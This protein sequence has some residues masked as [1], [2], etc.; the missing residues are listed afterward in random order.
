MSELPIEPVAEQIW[1]VPAGAR[2][3]MR[4]PA[5]VFADDELLSAICA[6]HSLEQLANVATLP[7]IVEAALAMPDIHQGYGFPVGGV[8][9]TEP[10]GGVVS[11]G[12]VGYDIN[13]G[14]RLL[15]LPL[16]VGELG[17][18]RASLV[19][20]IAR[21]VP[22]G[23]GGK[24]SRDG[25]RGVR[26]E[27]VLALGPRALLEDL[28]IGS[29]EELTVTESAGCLAGADPGQLSPRALER[30]AGQIG[31]LGSGN[32][33]LELQR[34]DRLYDAPSAR[35][36][37][38]REGQVTILI[39][40]GSRGLGHQVCTDF[41]KRMDA[42]LRHYGIELPDRQLSCAPL[43][44]PEAQAYLGAMAAAANFAWANRAALAH[45]ARSAVGAVLGPAAARGLRQVYD[46]AHNVAKLE[47]HD[48][49]TLC[50]HRKGA[51][52]AF[53]PGHPELP[54]AYRDAGQPVFIPGS[55]G[56]SSFVLAGRPRALELSFGT[57][58]HGAGRRLSRTAVRKQVRGEALRDRLERQGIAVQAGSARGLAEEAPEAYKDV[59]R[60]V[61][62]VQAVG[63]AAKVAQ[64]RPIGVIKG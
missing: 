59:E 43:D 33:F 55:M 26:L 53:P 30:G 31:T 48:G 23:A 34:V 46:V 40:S 52:R 38:L 16:D 25:L 60:V 44:S 18:R 35:A 49:R 1:E 47:Q 64:L 17:G 29:E 15:A 42:R 54:A 28:G 50:V 12:G 2:A 3:G 11:P 13:C 36:F 57:T 5:R 32:H 4:V 8:A 22:V 20:E 51:T 10:P 27:R 19:R 45:R 21:R 39:H 41:V 62:V 14:V 58:C 61:D 24:G 63:L 6:D 7:G 56:T 9:A 37:G